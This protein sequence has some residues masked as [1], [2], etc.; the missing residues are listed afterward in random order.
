MPL[1]LVFTEG[2]RRDLPLLWVYI[3]EYDYDA[4]DR[5]IREI[6]RAS[7]LL[8]E[9]PEMGAEPPGLISGQRSFV[10]G[11]HVIVYF[12]DAKKLVVNRVFDGRRDPSSLL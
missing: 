1:R 11:R 8:Y 5:A 6:Q 3:A 7:A 4:G 2:A 9:Q 10:V 12:L